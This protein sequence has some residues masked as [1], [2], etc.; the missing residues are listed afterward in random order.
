LRASSRLAT[1]LPPRFLALPLDDQAAARTLSV[2][3]SAIA[4]HSAHPD[5]YDGPCE[6]D[7]EASGDEDGGD[8][9]TDG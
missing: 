3:R 9:D 5:D 7:E 2:G 6:D 8:G 4:G 1:L